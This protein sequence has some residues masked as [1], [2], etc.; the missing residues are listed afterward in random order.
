[1]SAGRLRRARRRSRGAE[2]AVERRLDSG[3]GPDLLDEQLALLVPFEP[4]EERP[5]DRLMPGVEL[6]RAAR[7]LQTQGRECALE[8]PLAVRRVAV[9]PLE[10]LE[11]RFGLVEVR[12]VEQE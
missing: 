7:T 12:D 5:A 1:V 2:V 6:D 8:P 4:S 3:H 10:R 11:Q 9:Y